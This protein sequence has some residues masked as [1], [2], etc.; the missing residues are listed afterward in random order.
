MLCCFVV[1]YLCF[2]QLCSKSIRKCKFTS[3]LFT[4]LPPYNYF[5]SGKDAKYC[6]QPVNVCLCVYS[7]CILNKSA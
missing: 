6:D 7:E 5:A 3:C 4:T 1:Y 2:K